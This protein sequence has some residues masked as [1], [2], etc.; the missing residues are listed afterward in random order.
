MNQYKGEIKGKLG[1]KERTFK[2]TFESIVNIE[3]R[4]GKSVIVLTTD[5]AQAKYTFKD[6]IVI[7][8]EGLLATNNKIV[9]EAVG[10]LVMQTGIVGA[11][12]LAGNLLATAFTGESKEKSDPLA[13][14]ENNQ[15]NTQSSNT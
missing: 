13:T 8:H 11:S 5:M 1:D 6:L 14:A 4:T 7:L 2:L 12:E 15:K 10:D 3:N 9:Q